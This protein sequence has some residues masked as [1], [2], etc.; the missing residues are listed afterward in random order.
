MLE[1]ILELY[2]WLFNAQK[3]FTD[4]ETQ[5]KCIHVM[6]NVQNYLD[7]HGPEEAMYAIIAILN[8]ETSK[9]DEVDF[10]AFENDI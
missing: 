7:T 2:D 4:V 5:Q 6:T 10:V 3:D 9:M 1:N 8:R